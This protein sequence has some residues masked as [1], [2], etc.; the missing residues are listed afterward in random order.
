MNRQEANMSTAETIVSETVLEDGL[1]VLRTLRVP[2]GEIALVA[3]NQGV[4]W[5][6]TVEGPAPFLGLEFHGPLPKEALDN[7]E[8]FV[9]RLIG[10]AAPE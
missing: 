10:P 7:A 3:V 4:D 9:R 1:S 6:V 2:E 8:S 5:K